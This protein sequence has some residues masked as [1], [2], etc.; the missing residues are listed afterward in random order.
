MASKR[1][2]GP[3]RQKVRCEGRCR[4]CGRAGRPLDPAHIVPRSRIN[5][6]G[7]AED[8]LN[9]VPLCRSCHDD[10]HGIRGLE[11]LSRLTR[12]EQQYIV[13]LVG[14]GEAYRRTTRRQS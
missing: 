7:G 13:G 1:D 9:I 4:A 10:H 14:L 2:M 12:E 3:A 8:P 5:A 6:G 11:L